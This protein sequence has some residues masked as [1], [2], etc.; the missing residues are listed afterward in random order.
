MQ[1]KFILPQKN[2]HLKNTS[3][4]IKNEI[5]HK[6]CNITYIIQENQ[7]LKGCH[8]FQKKG[9]RGI[10]HWNNYYP[11]LKKIIICCEFCN[12]FGMKRLNQSSD[13]R[14]CSHHKFETK[15]IKIPKIIPQKKSNDLLSFS[16]DVCVSLPIR[17]S[18]FGFPTRKGSKCIR[19][20]CVVTRILK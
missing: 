4:S 7:I 11:S 10:D 13:L 6:R 20:N 3:Q 19:S 12:R 2:N 16:F 17:F 15:K 18:S 5:Y 8:Y 14:Y 1:Q 9:F